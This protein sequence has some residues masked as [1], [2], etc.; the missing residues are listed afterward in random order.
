MELRLKQNRYMGILMMILEITKVIKRLFC[1]PCGSFYQVLIA[2]KNFYFYFLTGREKKH[3]QY[4]VASEIYIKT[5][6]QDLPHMD[7][8][9]IL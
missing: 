8:R 4:K 9:R 7:N 5:Q 2:L 3:F 1:S 6:I